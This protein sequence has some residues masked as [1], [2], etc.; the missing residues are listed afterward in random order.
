MEQNEQGSY[1]SYSELPEIMTP[2]FF[3]GAAED[4]KRGYLGFFE[5]IWYSHT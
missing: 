2:G 4:F 3:S 5:A 1:S